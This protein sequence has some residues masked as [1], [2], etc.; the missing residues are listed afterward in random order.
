MKNLGKINLHGNPIISLPNIISE[1][2]TSIDLSNTGIGHLRPNIFAHLPSLTYINLSKNHRLVL[3]GVHSVSV[4]RIDLSYCNMDAIEINGF[5]NLLTAILRG[6]MF[7]QLTRTS[8]KNNKLLENLDLSMNSINHIQVD[9]FQAIK[10]LKQLDLSFNMIG[11]IERDTFKDNEILTNINLSRN[12]L[13][14]FSKIFA[15]SLTSFN[16]S[17]CEILTIAPDALNG[18]PEIVDLD[19]SN[20]LIT[21]IPDLLMSDTL[22]SLDLSLCR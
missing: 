2:L 17:S 19:L 9:T 15:A 14:H 3:E 4:K 16:M 11:N 6:N 5:P 8:F 13:S 20:N 10:H 18:L 7:R 1:S 12:Y 22:Q 21:A